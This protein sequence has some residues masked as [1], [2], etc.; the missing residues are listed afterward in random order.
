MQGADRQLTI[1]I[2][3]ITIILVTLYWYLRHWNRN[4][5]KGHTIKFCLTYQVMSLFQVTKRNSIFV[6]LIKASM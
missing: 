1:A 2:I 4:E 6:W 3:F 5:I